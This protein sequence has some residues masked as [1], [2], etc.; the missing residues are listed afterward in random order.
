[1]ENIFVVHKV[2]QM[3]RQTLFITFLIFQIS[4]F[5]QVGHGGKPLFK[6]Q[7]QLKSARAVMQSSEEEKIRLT[8]PAYED[9]RLDLESPRKGESFTFAYPHFVQLTPDNSGVVDVL[10]D[11]R[12]I[13]QL[14]ISS[15]GA[16][17]LNLVFDKFR[18]AEGDSLF[19]YDASGGYILGAFT[20]KTNKKWGG[21]ATAPVPGDEVVVEWRGR[22]FARENGSSI[23][24]GAVNHDFLNI[25]KILKSAGDFGASGSCHTDFT[26]FEDAVIV[27]NGRSTGQVIVGGTEYCTGTLMNNSNNDGTPYVLTAGHCLGNSVESEDIVFIMN[28]EVPVCQEQIQG[29]QMQSLSGSLLRAYAD[30]LDF[31]LIEMTETPPASYRPVYAGWDLNESPA[32]GTH[33]V[34]HPMGDVKKVAADNEIPTPVTFNAS[35]VLGNSFLS[36]AH[37]KIDEW[38]EGTTEAGSSGAGLFLEDGKLIG[39][40][41]GGAASCENPINDYFARLNR[42]WNHYAEDTA[43]VDKWLN[44]S[45]DG[46]TQLEALDP[47]KGAVL[48]LTHFTPEMNPVL[49][50]VSGGTGSWTGNNSEG[51]VA[52]AEQ[53]GEVASA[54][55]YGV[56]LMPGLNGQLGDGN[57]TVKIWSGIDEPEFVVAEQT[58]SINSIV[59]KEF[60]VLFDEPVMVSGPFFA[61]YDL[62]YTPTV[63]KWAVYQANSVSGVNTVLLETSAG[64]NHYN[65]LSGDS[66]AMAWIDVLADEVIYSDSATIDLPS[67]GFEVVPNPV[68]QDL[69]IF[70]PED[71]AGI[72]TIFNLK[73]QPVLERNVLIYGNRGEIR[74]VGE[75][76]SKGAYLVQFQKNG[77]KLVRK[78]M[79]K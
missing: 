37:W 35:S 16:Y 27:E 31:A 43:R 60:L 46:R 61:G 7:G 65:I 9:I 78:L 45:G 73:G 72:V 79:V 23:E 71:G 67:D 5:A 17:S 15:P 58:V 51:V 21:L 53:F 11:G 38:D 70:Y 49:K 33:T 25:F 34:H 50:N 28:Y 4:A 44:P 40:L 48:R 13:W 10:D 52:V 24:I 55:I 1:L 74:G 66:P 75:K 14:R 57:L 12:L 47:G 36:D 22:D 77:K 42:I 29:S 30:R 76:L 8:P 68:E 54:R 64:W 59:N 32:T 20:D 63:D 69:V 19:I 56:F 18:M 26:C 39:L 2:K 3:L 41:S 62:D 6:N